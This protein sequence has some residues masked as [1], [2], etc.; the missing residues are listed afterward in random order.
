MRSLVRCG[1]ALGLALGFGA[2]A[3]GQLAFFWSPPSTELSAAPG[4][5]A[6]F[7]CT[8]V[9]EGNEVTGFKLYLTEVVERE[10]GYYEFREGG[11]P[12]PR[13]C[14]AWLAIAP[15]TVTLKPKE[16]KDVTVT[17]TVPRGTTPGGR[18]AA[19]C[20]EVYKQSVKDELR[21]LALD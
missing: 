21:N 20:C 3:R 18:Y 2:G 4:S 15:V 19:V 9:N 5:K 1:L 8:I 16:F 10:E 6:Q 13:S 12:G 11:V 14:T 17:V 7:V